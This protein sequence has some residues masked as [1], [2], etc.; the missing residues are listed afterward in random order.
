MMF[1]EKHSKNEFVRIFQKQNIFWKGQTTF[2]ISE[3]LM[4]QEHFWFGEPKSNGIFWN[5]ELKK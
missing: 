3:H 5:F 2:G 1:F 4:N